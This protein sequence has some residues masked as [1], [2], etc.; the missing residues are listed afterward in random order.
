MLRHIVLFRFKPS[1]TPADLDGLV[2]TLTRLVTGFPGITAF[3][4]GTNVNPEGKTHGFTH[5]FCMTFTD[6]AARDSY[7]PHPGHQAFVDQL[8]PFE[9]DVL[10]I[11]YAI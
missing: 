10:V 5:A 8:R 4:W 3:E 2:A 6:A 11:D 9:D 1:A 7:L